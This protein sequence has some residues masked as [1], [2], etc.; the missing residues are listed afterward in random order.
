MT[1]HQEIWRKIMNNFPLVENESFRK[2]LSY[3]LGIEPITDKTILTY[4]NS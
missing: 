4:I 2:T 3:G 1:N